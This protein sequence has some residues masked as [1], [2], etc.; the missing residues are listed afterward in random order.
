MKVAIFSDLHIFA[1]LSKTQFEDIAINFIYSL[2]DKCK[3]D[4]IKQVFF[5]GDWFHIKNKLYVP[6]FIKSIEVLKNI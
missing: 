6:P 3:K 1:H 5:L 2:L 4:G